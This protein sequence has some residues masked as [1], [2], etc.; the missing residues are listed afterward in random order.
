M[1]EARLFELDTM[2]DFWGRYRYP[3]KHF[4]FIYFSVNIFY[5]LSAIIIK[6]NIK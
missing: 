1:A 2:I 5:I 3:K 4:L 6:L